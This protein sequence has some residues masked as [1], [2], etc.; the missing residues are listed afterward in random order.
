MWRSRSFFIYPV[1]ESCTAWKAENKSS[2]QDT[3]GS[4]DGFTIQRIAVLPS[5][6]GVS[7]CQP[8]GLGQLCQE[9]Q[10]TA[11]SWKLS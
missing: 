7:A 3:V 4:N 8:S 2:S 9:D 1:S 10:S 6:V 5:R 11:A